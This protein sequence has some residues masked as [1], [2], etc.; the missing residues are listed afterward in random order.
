MDEESTAWTQDLRS[1]E[2]DWWTCSTY[3]NAENSPEKTNKRQIN[4]RLQLKCSKTTGRMGQTKTTGG[5]RLRPRLQERGLRSRLQE[6]RLRARLRANAN[7]TFDE[8]HPQLGVLTVAA[9][10]DGGFGRGTGV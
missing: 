3:L 8:R 10:L 2:M 9:G 7:T 6:G 4:T 5:G 1:E